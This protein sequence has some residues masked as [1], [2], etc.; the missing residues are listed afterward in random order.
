VTGFCIC[1]LLWLNLSHT[2]I[3][4]GVIWMAVGISFGAWKT[5]G[6][7]KNLINFELPAEDA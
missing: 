3:L 5:H 1:L 2:A 4:A 6:F 7:R